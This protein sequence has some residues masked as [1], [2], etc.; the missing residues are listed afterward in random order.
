MAP[1]QIIMICLVNIDIEPALFSDFFL[2]NI[3]ILA[4]KASTLCNNV[5]CGAKEMFIDSLGGTPTNQFTTP[6][7]LSCCK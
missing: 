4:R 5:P 7:N 3:N 6:Q 1:Y 2:L